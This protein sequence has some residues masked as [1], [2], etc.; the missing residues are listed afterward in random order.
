MGNSVYST[1]FHMICLYK[2]VSIYRNFYIK[3]KLVKTDEFTSLG[4]CEPTEDVLMV[5]S[6]LLQYI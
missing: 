5:H 3:F 6:Q 1:S 2:G 4:K